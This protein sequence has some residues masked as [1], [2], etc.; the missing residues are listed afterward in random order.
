MIDGNMSRDKLK[1]L[2]E[3]KVKTETPSAFAKIYRR[4][5][6]SDTV[7]DYR[8]W[9]CPAPPTASNVHRLH[10]VNFTCETLAQAAQLKRVLLANVS[11]MS[12]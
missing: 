4:V 6:D 3:E 2:T 5:Y 12:K 9:F 8:V 10:S 7:V 1:L 11:T